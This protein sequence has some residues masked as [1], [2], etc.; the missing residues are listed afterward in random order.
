MGQPGWAY[1]SRSNRWELR[2][3]GGDL[4]L[5]IGDATRNPILN[6]T[7]FMGTSAAIDIGTIGIFHTS[8]LGSIGNA[9]GLN[10]HDRVIGVPGTAFPAAAGITGFRVPTT[11]TLNVLITGSIGVMDW[12]I[13]AFHIGD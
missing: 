10:F 12:Y 13:T 3:K 6:T 8:V 4:K 1:N 2:G 9:K 5:A 11:D 7:S